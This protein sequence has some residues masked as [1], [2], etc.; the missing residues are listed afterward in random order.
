MSVDVGI[1]LNE[2]AKPDVFRADDKMVMLVVSFYGGVHEAVACRQ[3][4][5]FVDI[6]E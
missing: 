4:N 3:E 5:G 6:F 1:D 2:D